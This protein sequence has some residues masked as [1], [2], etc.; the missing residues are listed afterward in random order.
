MQ[1]AWS[2]YLKGLTPGFMARSD[3]HWMCEWWTHSNQ[4]LSTTHQAHNPH[5]AFYNL[6]NGDNVR[7]QITAEEL[8]PI[9]SVFVT[10]MHCCNHW[11]CVLKSFVSPVCLLF[12]QRPWLFHHSLGVDTNSIFHLNIFST[13]IMLD[14]GFTELSTGGDVVRFYFHP[15]IT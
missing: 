13:F 2:I 9:H 15:V 12:S 14:D 10:L 11:R 8:S 6:W 1:E 7:K 3:L 5:P 4:V